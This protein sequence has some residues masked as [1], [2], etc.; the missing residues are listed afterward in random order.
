[1]DEWREELEARVGERL[2]SQLPKRKR[3]EFEAIADD[4]EAIAWV[5][6]NCP[7]RE[8]VIEEVTHEMEAARVL[9]EHESRS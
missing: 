5:S 4:S 9:D 7:N 3:R 1:M 6:A 2:F 8:A